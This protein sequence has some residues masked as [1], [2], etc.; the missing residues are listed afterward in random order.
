MGL[1]NHSPLLELPAGPGPN[2]PHF[3]ASLSLEQPGDWPDVCT[4]DVQVTQSV[5][6]CRAV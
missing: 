6:D 4:W 5:L 1:A 3:V 2:C